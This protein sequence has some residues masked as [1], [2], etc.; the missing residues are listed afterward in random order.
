MTNMRQPSF[1][2]ILQLGRGGFS[3]VYKGTYHDDPVAIK[4]LY[5]TVNKIGD[6]TR[7]ID[8]MRYAFIRHPPPKRLPV[9]QVLPQMLW[10]MLLTI[11]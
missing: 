4:K 9:H 7:E 11:L 2:T 3:V 1:A 6:V 10:L 5:L 8:I